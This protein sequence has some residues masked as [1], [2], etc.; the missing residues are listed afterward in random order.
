MF[1]GFPLELLPVAVCA[2]KILSADPERKYETVLPRTYEVISS[3][4]PQRGIIFLAFLSWMDGTT[5]VRL[6]YRLA[7][8]LCVL[9]T[10]PSVASMAIFRGLFFLSLDRAFRSDRTPTKRFRPFGFCFGL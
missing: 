4:H 7:T 10:V 9:S 3:S 1:D 2:V 8:G 6:P 5:S